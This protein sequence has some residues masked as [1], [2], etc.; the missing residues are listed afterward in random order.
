MYE[1]EEG[2]KQIVFKTLDQ[3][4]KKDDLVVVPTSTRHGMTVTKVV[5]VDV[6]V[7]Y[8]SPVVIDWIVAKVDQDAYQTLLA[9]EGEALTVIRSAER[10]KKRN[11]LR[12]AML[13]DSGA[14]LKCLPI[15]DME[16]STTAPAGE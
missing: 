16:A 10:T 5:E 7:D 9:Q 4:I 1:P 14:A 11:E 2:K 13:A 12:E 6:D 15:A 8:D 3:T